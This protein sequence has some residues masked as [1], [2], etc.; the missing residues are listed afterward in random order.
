M[1]EMRILIVEDDSE[2]GAY[3]V[4]AFREQGHVAD[5]AADGLAGYAAAAEGHYDVLD[6]RPHAAASSTDSR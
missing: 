1:R 4:K 6:R 3:L 2:A 5:H